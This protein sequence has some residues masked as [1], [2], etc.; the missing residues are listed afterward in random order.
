MKCLPQLA[1]AATVL[2]MLMP[3]QAQPI[4]PGL[5]EFSSS[6]IEVDGQQMPGMDEMLRQLGNL[7]AEQRH[8][9]EE[10]LAAQGVRLG[11]RGVQVCLSEAQVAAGE[12]PF[13]DNPAC[14]HEITER[15]DAL[16]KFRFECPD[17]RGHGEARFIS[18]REFV[19]S[20]QSEYRQGS[21]TGHTRMQSHARWVSADCPASR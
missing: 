13:Q 18:P 14:R 17:A 8:A 11:E 16:W 1:A 19:S 15:S 21:E 5:W 4:Q 10:M 2:L 6:D 7:P 20:V 9:M 12:L 3:A